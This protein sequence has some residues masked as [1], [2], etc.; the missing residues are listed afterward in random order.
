MGN[1]DIALF[2]LEKGARIDIFAATMLDKLDI[3]KAI[4]EDGPGRF[5]L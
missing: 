4:I 1:R 3:I 5:T 2:L